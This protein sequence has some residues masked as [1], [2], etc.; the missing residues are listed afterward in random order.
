M[1]EENK[2][3]AR[4]FFEEIY[5]QGRLDL[6]D[7]IIA[8]NYVAEGAG[9]YAQGREAVK[10][11]ITDKPPGTNVKVEEQISE[12]D[13]VVSRLAF[14]A[15]G[16]SWVGVAIQRIANGKLVETWRLTNRNR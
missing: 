5:S 2:A 7:D 14:S 4:R 10:R 1:S 16:E 15:N 3:I 11:S 6:V 9:P 12:G 13:K 8:P